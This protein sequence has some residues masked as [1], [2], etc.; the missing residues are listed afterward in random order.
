MYLC[1]WEGGEMRLSVREEEERGT[2][3]DRERG[4]KIKKIEKK[5]G[6]KKIYI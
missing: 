5:K 6:K 2:E 3:K 1:V 4:R